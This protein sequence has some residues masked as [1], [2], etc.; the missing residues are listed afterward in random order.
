M[1][2]LYHIQ[3]SIQLLALI[4]IIFGGFSQWGYARSTRAP[5]QMSCWWV[6][7]TARSCNKDFSWCVP[8]F[9]WLPTAE[10]FCADHSCEVLH[11]CIVSEIYILVFTNILPSDFLRAEQLYWFTL[12][13]KRRLDSEIF[14]MTYWLR[15]S[16][17]VS[18]LSVQFWRLSSYYNIVLT[19]WR[20][21]IILVSFFLALLLIHRLDDCL[22]SLILRRLIAAA[23]LVPP[24]TRLYQARLWLTEVWTM[25]A[26]LLS[27]DYAAEFSAWK[28][29]SPPR[30]GVDLSWGDAFADAA[31]SNQRLATVWIRFQKIKYLNGKKFL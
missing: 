15:L 9:S 22:H 10:T 16:C 14:W 1:F 20:T 19:D 2:I 21:K 6:L 30:E 27:L 12:E 23:P 3:R 7:M 25:E 5:V 11:Y 28:R 31:K 18:S 17:A 29:S 26:A 24:A 13:N 8:H 4:H